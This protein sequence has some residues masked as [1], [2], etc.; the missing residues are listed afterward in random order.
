MQWLLTGAGMLAGAGYPTTD[1]TSFEQ[2]SSGWRTATGR[3]VRGRYDWNSPQPGLFIGRVSKWWFGVARLTPP[4]V[5]AAA[6]YLFV[7]GLGV[8]KLNNDQ[9][10]MEFRG[11]VRNEVYSDGGRNNFLFRLC[12]GQQA[13]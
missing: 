10:W 5:R 3:V 12:D 7:P 6:F 1:F 8:F 4:L 11:R 13:A 9:A 2:W